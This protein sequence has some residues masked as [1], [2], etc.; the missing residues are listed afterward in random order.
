[1]NSLITVNTSLNSETV[2]ISLTGALH[3][4]EESVSHLILKKKKAQKPQECN[5]LQAAAMV[6]VCP[7]FKT[8]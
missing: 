5:Y 6:N 7:K 3:Y 8:S 4:T 2:K 1:M